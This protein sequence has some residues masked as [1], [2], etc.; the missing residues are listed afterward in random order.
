[1]HPRAMYLLGAARHNHRLDVVTP[2]GA[3]PFDYYMVDSTRIIAIEV[4]R[5]Q[6]T[7]GYFELVQ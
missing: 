2:T 6:N 4:D 7:L 3:D 5:N 1:M